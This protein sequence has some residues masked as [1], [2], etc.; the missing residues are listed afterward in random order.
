[1]TTLDATYRILHQVPDVPTYQG[2]RIGAGLSAKSHEAASRG[3]PNTLF[4]VLVLHHGTAVGMGRVIGDG[5]TA[6]QVVDVAVLPEHQGRGLGKRIMR[7]ISDYLARA[8]P[9]GGYVS[10]I[11]DGPAK[12]LYAQFGFEPT[13]PASIGMARLYGR[14]A[15]EVR[16]ETAVERAAAPPAAGVPRSGH[17]M[18]FV[19]RAPTFPVVCDT[20]SRLLVARSK[21][22]LASGLAKVGVADAE[23]REMVDA[24]GE[25]FC[26][27][28]VSSIIAPSMTRPRWTKL[29]VITLYNLK[30]PAGAP[31]LR[32]TSLG[33]RTLAQVIGEVVE[34]LLP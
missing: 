20:G 34:R 28:T 2:L 12:D 5:G 1:M 22:Q 9:D 3:L 24:T 31:E 25:G 23:R 11:A 26:L 7:E 16:A 15:G 14:P 6:F 32:T 19:F 27:Y 29:Q 21:A 13:A 33:N 30:R 8:V 18:A 4:G 10:L 17:E